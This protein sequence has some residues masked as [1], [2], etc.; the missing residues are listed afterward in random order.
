MKITRKGQ[1][2]VVT[3][4][5]EL[6]TIPLESIITPDSIKYPEPLVLFK[7]TSKK[8]TTTTVG[9]HKLETLLTTSEQVWEITKQKNIDAYLAGQLRA[10]DLYSHSL[11]KD[12]SNLVLLDEEQ[13]KNA[14]NH[15]INHFYEKLL[16]LKDLMNTPTGKTLAE[17]RH[18]F[19]ENFLDEF[20]EEWNL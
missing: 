11:N 17:K 18:K 20:Y 9:N 19:M 4:E 15:T 13:V 7:I 2:S 5:E 12:I 16:K 14:E 10:E 8:E 6:S 3:V 1:K